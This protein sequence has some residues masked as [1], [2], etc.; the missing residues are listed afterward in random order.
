MSVT[1]RTHDS[2]RLHTER[3][4]GVHQSKRLP[5]SSASP[6]T[7]PSTTRLRPLLARTWATASRGRRRRAPRSRPRGTRSRSAA[8]EDGVK[9]LLRELIWDE[10]GIGGGDIEMGDLRRMS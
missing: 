2:L 3:L 5:D 9:D 10:D 1:S 8:R 6:S 4:R 7:S